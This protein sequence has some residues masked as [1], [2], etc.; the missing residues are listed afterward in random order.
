VCT[1]T[2]KHGGCPFCLGRWATPSTSLAARRPDLAAEW[3]PT[4]NGLLS[5]VDV[6]AG[7]NRAVWWRCQRGHQ[8]RSTAQARTRPGGTRCPRCA[9]R[10][11]HWLSLLEVAPHL[12]KEWVDE[13]NDGPGG[14][15]AAGSNR[16][17][18]WRCD[19]GHLWQA[20]VQ[21]RTRNGHGCPYCSGRRASPERNLAVCAP[22]W[23]PS[24][25]RAATRRRPRPRSRP[26]RPAGCGGAVLAGTCGSARSPNG[27][28]T[29]PDVHG[30]LWRAGATSRRAP[31][32]A[33]RRPRL[34]SPACCCSTPPPDRRNH[35]DTRHA[36]ACSAS[37]LV[38]SRARPPTTTHDPGDASAPVPL[39]RVACR[40]GTLSEDFRICRDPRASPGCAA[41]PHRHGSPAHRHRPRR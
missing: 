5:P 19:R 13:L 23:P 37:G 10:T 7:S 25:I 33:V 30:A 11:H 15:V 40:H 12:V 35:T 17:V 29:E 8:W 36:Q 4:R 34:G 9:D 18:W 20:R 1:R 28:R 14:L 24:G 2:S 32:Q 31:H 21:S 6:V 41:A 38:W 16:R 26:A 3:H 27:P 39:R 22:R